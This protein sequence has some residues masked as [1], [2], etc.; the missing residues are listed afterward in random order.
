M[1]PGGKLRGA[2]SKPGAECGAGGG[3]P[4]RQALPRRRLAGEASEAQALGSDG[5]RF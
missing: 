1:D 3:Q 4:A 2:S 5:S